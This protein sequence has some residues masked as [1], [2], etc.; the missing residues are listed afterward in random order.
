MTPEEIYKSVDLQMNAFDEDDD[1]CLPRDEWMAEGM[2]GPNVDSS[3]VIAEVGLRIGPDRR[4]IL[5]LKK[6][7]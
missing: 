1:W 2:E 3:W 7:P 6:T 4:S 5:S